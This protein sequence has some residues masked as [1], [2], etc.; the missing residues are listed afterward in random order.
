MRSSSKSPNQNIVEVYENNFI[1]EI[2]R[3]GSYLEK[4]PIIGMD[5]EFPGLVYPCPTQGFY[6][7]Y[8][9]TNVDKLKL[10]QLGVSLFNENGESPPEGA[11]WQFNLRFNCEKE[12]YSRESITLLSNSGIDFTQ[13]KK[14]GIHYSTFAEYLITSGL[15]LNECVK[16]ISFNGFSDF[17]Y[18]LRLIINSNLPDII[19]SIEELVSDENNFYFMKNKYSQILEEYENL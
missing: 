8:I 14:N 6:Y 5:T 13:L 16:W 9:K 15:V 4:Y 18:L 10:I 11:T 19:N 1:Q 3:L 7:K 12:A 17:A 2:K